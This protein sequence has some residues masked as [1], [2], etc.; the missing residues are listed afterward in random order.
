MGI[1][2]ILDPFYIS[3]PSETFRKVPSVGQFCW[4]PVPHLDPIPRILDIE[5]A[6]P[7]EHYATKFSIRNMQN[8]D[9][10]KKPRLPIKMLSLRETEELIIC[11]TKKRP[12]IIISADF[13]I[14]D[15]VSQELRRL[16]RRHLQEDNIIIVPLYEAET[17]EHKGGFPPI[18]AARIRT[19][20]YNQFFF[21]PKTD[22]GLIND[23]IA[24]L[25]RIQVIKPIYPTYEP[26]QFALSLETLPILMEMLRSLFG[27][28]EGKDLRALRQLLIE[29]LPDEAKIIK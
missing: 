24:R 1:T 29:F 5:R 17:V 13:T 6:D 22:L 20:M 10:R 2:Q 11:R 9:F 3:L 8:K 21:C 23:S 7:T 15:D 28:E 27:A 12:G 26:K 18:M 19:L 25:D 4:V 14:F 16:G